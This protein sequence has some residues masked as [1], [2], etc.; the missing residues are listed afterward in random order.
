VPL[1][2]GAF[3]LEAMDAHGGWVSSTVDLLRFVTA[4]DGLPARP[5]VLGPASIATM[6]AKPPGLWDG[7]ALHYGMGW[8]V[9]PAEGNWSHGGSL[10]GTASML[11]R[12]DN[13]LA[14]AALFNA[15]A[16]VANSGFEQQIEAKLWQAISGV[17]EWPTHDLFSS[18]S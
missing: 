6:T 5:D 3:Y 8:L 7:S 4:V 12:T 16:M 17:T 15:R 1:P 14:W 13:G 9:R 10:P 18:M 11:V 2:Y